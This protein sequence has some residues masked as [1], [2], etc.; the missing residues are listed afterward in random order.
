MKKF[1]QYLTEAK[2]AK[3]DK[4][5]QDMIKQLYGYYSPG[6]FSEEEIQAIIDYTGNSYEVI[7]RYLYKG[8]DNGTLPEDAEYVENTVNV[9]DSAFNETQAPFAYTIY[10]GLSQRYNAEDLI[11]GNQYMFR[12]YVSGTLDYKNMLTSFSKTSIIL[13]IGINQGQ[14]SIFVDPLMQN[15][16]D[17]EV[18]LPRASRIQLINGPQ[19][20]DEQMVDKT[21]GNPIMFFT[22]SLVSV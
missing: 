11:L 17:L 6:L 1:D 22:C 20:Y 13:Q 9:L 2:T 4:N 18:L 5:L 15:S 3:K 21:T 8:H 16:Q 10:T 14:P 12:G 19:V 7:N